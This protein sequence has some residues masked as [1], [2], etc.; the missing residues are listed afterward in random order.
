MDSAEDI[1]L[2][3][4]WEQMG[5]LW[6]ADK[7]TPAVLE[8]RT[9]RVRCSVSVGE[10]GGCGSRMWPAPWARCFLSA[11]SAGGIVRGL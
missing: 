4:L 11:G 7:E 5:G 8:T 1:A 10:S 9:W 2:V 3:T 6:N